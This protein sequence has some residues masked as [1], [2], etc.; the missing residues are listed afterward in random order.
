VKRARQLGEGGRRHRG[1]GAQGRQ[2]V[3]GDLRK[4]QVDPGLAHAALAL[5][6]FSESEVMLRKDLEL[7]ERVMVQKGIRA[8]FVTVCTLPIV[9]RLGNR[10]EKGAC[11]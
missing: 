6:V 2:G 8:G 9:G 10:V 3:I 1:Y 11:P 4:M 7:F 5:V